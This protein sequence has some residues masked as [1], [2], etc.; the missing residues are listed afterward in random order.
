MDASIEAYTV[1]SA[2]LHPADIA[3]RLLNLP[4]HEDLKD[5]EATIDWLLKRDEK[6]KGGRTIL[7]TVHMPRVQGELSECFEWLL[8]RL[9]GRQPD[10]LIVLDQRYWFEASPLHREILVYHELTHCIHKRDMYGELL[11]TLDDRPRW[12]LRGHDV[13][14]FAAV[15]RRYGAWNDEIRGF[16]AAAEAH[17]VSERSS[18]G[19]A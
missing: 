17:A 12:G 9:L 2:D 15:V 19:A 16:I 18:S 7:G 3:A 13:E 6:V 8:S 5:G 10:F 14:E 4:E 11:Y 1:P